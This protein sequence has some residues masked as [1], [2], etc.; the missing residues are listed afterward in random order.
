[1]SEWAKD[2]TV[3]WRSVKGGDSTR[4][5]A[6]LVIWNA[7]CRL[8]SLVLRDWDYIIIFAIIQCAGACA[9]STSN[10]HEQTFFFFKEDNQGNSHKK[11]STRLPP[12]PTFSH[13]KKH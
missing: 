4:W 7:F 10:T 1:M 6:S 8:F 9:S 2:N 3:G 12:V 5:G 11:L 13:P